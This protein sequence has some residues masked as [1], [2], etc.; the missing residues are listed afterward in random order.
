MKKKIVEDL[1]GRIVTLLGEESREAKHIAESE[2]NQS[3]F[4]SY[5]YYIGKA[6]GVDKALGIIEGIYQSYKHEK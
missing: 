6:E 2:K 3:C 1:I 5:N 4:D